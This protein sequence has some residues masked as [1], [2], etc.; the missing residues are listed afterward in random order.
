MIAI[1]KVDGIHT[2][3]TTVQG[4]LKM[5]LVWIRIHIMMVRVISVL[6]LA[7]WIFFVPLQNGIAGP[8]GDKW[9]IPGNSEKICGRLAGGTR[10]A[11]RPPAQFRRMGVPRP[12]EE[13]QGDKAVKVF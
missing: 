9:L 2:S 1:D 3:R 5:L 11:T 4:Y 12:K 7:V 10:V 13:N 6:S 8:M